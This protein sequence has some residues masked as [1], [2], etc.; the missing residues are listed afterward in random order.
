MISL[1]DEFIE[2][3]RQIG[4]NIGMDSVVGKIIGTLFLEPAELSLDEIAEKTGYSLATISNKMRLMESIGLVNR[5]R[6]PSSKKVY[7]NM[8]RD[9]FEIMQRKINICYRLHVNGAKTYLPTL[10]QKYQKKK[11]SA[12]QK[13]KLSAIKK[14]Y[15]QSLLMEKYLQEQK[16]LLQKFKM[17]VVK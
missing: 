11:L 3:A 7:Y 1:D 12:T 9:M 2:F 13:A 16:K 6:K 8:Q 10:I 4:R 5:L 15:R 17:R 14:F